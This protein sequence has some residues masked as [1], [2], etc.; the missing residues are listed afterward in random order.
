LLFNE[1]RTPPD[2]DFEP[3]KRYLIRLAS[4][5]SLACTEFHIENHILEIVGVDGIHTHPHI[6][7]A[8]K[9]CP[10]QR[11][12]I[13]VVGLPDED[14]DFNW[15]TKMRTD[16]LT[17]NIPSDKKLSVIGNV[18]Y[19]RKNHLLRGLRN[20]SFR[21]RK[22]KGITA[23]W[24]PEKVLDDMEL[25]PLDNT[26]LLQPV[27]CKINLASNQTYY[28][29]LGT[30]TGMGGQPWTEPKVPT[31]FTVL[32]TGDHAFNKST[33]GPGVD[34]Y[35]IHSD[36]VVQVYMENSQDW[37]HPMHIHGMGPV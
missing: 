27:D 9:I 2:F 31:L 1:S 11:Y 12:D 30:R 17:K 3:H 28:D 16:M 37:P 6:T 36:E 35:I 18:R 33:Y 34:P 23:A 32:T 26:P 4:M 21:G 24:K 15:I 25:K 5:A 20:K 8:I 19:P 29:G 10:G 7:D 13:L 22:G 14:Q